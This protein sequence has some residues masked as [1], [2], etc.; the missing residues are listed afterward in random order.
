MNRAIASPP[1]RVLR[2]EELRIDEVAFTATLAS[3]KAEV[4]G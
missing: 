1:Y 4:R 2:T 3:S